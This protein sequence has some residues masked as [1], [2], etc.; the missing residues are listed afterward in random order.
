MMRPLLAALALALVGCA[1]WRPG[2]LRAPQ[3]DE[4]ERVNKAYWKGFS[5]GAGRGWRMGREQ[6][7][8]AGRV[9][10]N[11]CEKADEAR[12]RAEVPACVVDVERMP[13]SEKI[14][15]GRIKR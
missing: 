9:T 13:D 5:D 8:Q 10:V 1:P 12:I 11:G 14:I 7:L 6:G 15:D 4:Q 3:G 2:T